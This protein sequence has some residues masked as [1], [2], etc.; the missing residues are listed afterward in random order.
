MV[1]EPKTQII[2]VFRR[3]CTR[4]RVIRND[5]AD[6]DDDLYYTVRRH[7]ALVFFAAL[8]KG[9]YTLKTGWAVGRAFV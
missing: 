6:K 4:A 9:L 3:D 1:R 5:A 8:D 7:G 2:E